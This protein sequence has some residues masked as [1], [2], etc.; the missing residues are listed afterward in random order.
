LASRLRD[1]KCEN[2]PEA[3][4]E[5]I[6]RECTRTAEFP[7]GKIW[8][9]NKKINGKRELKSTPVEAWSGERTGHFC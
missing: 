3:T 1:L 9:Y 6:P 7:N 8:A 2:L 5:S 4:I